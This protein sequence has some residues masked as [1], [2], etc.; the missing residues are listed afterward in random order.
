MELKMDIP[1]LQT[2]LD[3]QFPQVA[4]ELEVVALT[5]DGLTVKLKV[6]DQ[7]LR[8]G[9][10]VSGPSILMKSISSRK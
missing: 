4:G 3:A 2:F 8:P 7:H 5:D 1:A 6:Q 9:G 10:T